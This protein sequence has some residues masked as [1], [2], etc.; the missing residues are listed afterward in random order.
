MRYIIIKTRKKIINNLFYVFLCFQN[1]V[2]KNAF[3][4]HVLFSHFEVTIIENTMPGLNSF[5]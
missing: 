2:S 4:R 1:H 5:F 3:V